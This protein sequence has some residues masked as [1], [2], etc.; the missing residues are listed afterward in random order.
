MR[1]NLICNMLVN[2]QGIRCILELGIPIFFKF[3]VI[4]ML[5]VAIIIW[6]CLLIL[7]V[8]LKFKIIPVTKLL[9]EL[10]FLAFLWT[11]PITGWLLPAVLFK[12]ISVG[13]GVLFAGTVTYVIILLWTGKL[14]PKI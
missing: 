10:M 4:I 8:L 2:F 7:T 14:K 3:E 1:V 6:A 13:L 12:Y 9:Y 5:L 11:F